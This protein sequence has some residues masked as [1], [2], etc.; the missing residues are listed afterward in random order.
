MAG[1]GLNEEKLKNGTASKKGKNEN[2]GLAPD[3]IRQHLILE[4]TVI[5]FTPGR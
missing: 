5:L 4:V 3:R 2:E 1:K